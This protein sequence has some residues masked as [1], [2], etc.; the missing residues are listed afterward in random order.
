MTETGQKVTYTYDDLVAGMK[1]DGWNGSPLN[2]VKMP[3]GS[4][5]SIDNTRLLAA[6]EAGIDA[7]VVIHNYADGMPNASA[8]EYARPNMAVPKTWGEAIQSRIND[9]KT[10]FFQD[11]T[12]SEQFKYGTIYDPK[13][14]GKRKV[15]SSEFFKA[16]EK[17][18]GYSYPASYK[19]FVGSQKLSSI[20][21]WWF[22]GSSEGLFDISFNLLNI[23]LASSIGLIPFAKSEETKALAFF[24][25]SGKV[26]FYIGE[27]SLENIDWTSR[28]SLPDF[29]SWLEK[30]K[31]GEV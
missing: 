7:K 11:R 8:L 17:L 26:Y 19:Q 20:E 23:D 5:S 14:T 28:F 12:F 25:E 18:V 24:D 1:A 10:T 30:V 2:V 15:M 13:V 29:D 16:E 9:Q 3:D 27:S 22:I 31:L 6:R 21:P 4:L